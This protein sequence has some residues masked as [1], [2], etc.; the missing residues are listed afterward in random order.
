M[1]DKDIWKTA[2]T[3]VKPNEIRV[4]GYAIDELMGRVDFAGVVFL[5]FQGRLPD[6]GERKLIDAILVSSIDHGTT[7][8]STLATRTVASCNVPL[9]SAI[10]AG[11]LSI[12]K[13]HGGAVEGCMESLMEIVDLARDKGL[14]TTVEEYLNKLKDEGKRMPGLGHRYH[15]ND[16]RTVRLFEIAEELKISGKYI[17]ALKEVKESLKRSSG[18]DLPI[19]VDG[20]IGASLLELGFEPQTGNAFFIISRVPGLI[21]HTL[22]EYSMPTMRKIYPD[23]AQYDG[24]PPKKL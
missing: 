9:T 7:P 12:G 1:D 18:K 3:D 6:E 19:N 20:A 11:L 5:L 14:E 2:I 15:T 10:T 8:P 13:S 21:C 17:Q 23:T 4:R 24:P 16:P 22:E